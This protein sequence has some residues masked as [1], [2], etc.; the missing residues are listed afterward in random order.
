MSA[1]ARSTGSQLEAQS[2]DAGRLTFARRV[3]PG[4]RPHRMP[5]ALQSSRKLGPWR[6]AGAGCNSAADSVW[7]RSRRLS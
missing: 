5:P 6:P 1:A 3:S 7:R 2:A 4:R